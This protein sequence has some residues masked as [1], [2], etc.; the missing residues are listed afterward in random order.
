MLTRL[1]NKDEI[2][3]PSFAIS[4][5]SKYY[6]F[7]CDK[8]LRNIA[9][10]YR[11]RKNK[12]G[13]KLHAHTKALINRGIE[14]EK[15]ILNKLSNVFDCRE[16]SPSKS[17]DFL[18]NS[19]T[20]QVFYQLK[21]KVPEELYCDL[22]IVGIARFKHFVPDFIKVVEEDGEKK[23]MILDAK[24]SKTVRFSHQFQVASY[25]YLLNYVIEKI[26]GLSISRTG[27]IYLPPF[28][29]HTFRMD[30]ILPK[31]DQ[32]FRSELPRILSAQSV[33]WHYNSRCRTC[34]YVDDCRIDAEDSMAM[35]PYLSVEKAV[36]LK[37]LLQDWK[38]QQSALSANYLEGSAK[39]ILDESG[40]GEDADIE[41][42]ANYFD[43]LKIE[44]DKPSDRMIKQITKYDQHINN[45]PYIKARKDRQAQFVGT[46]TAT[47]PQKT[48]HNVIISMSVDPF[49]LRPFAW[50]VGLYSGDGNEIKSFCY[51]ESITG[52][53]EDETHAAFVTL[54]GNFIMRLEGIFEYLAK[55]NS[56]AC[57]FVF[58]TQE[59]LVIQ[60]SLL[61]IV[62]LDPS[63]I[64]PE[65]QN[66]ATRCLFN[67]F[68]DCS[69]L[70]ATSKNTDGDITE[71]P[72]GWREFPR[73]VIL[74]NAIQENVA[75]DVAGFY[76]FED[77][78]KQMVR[79]TIE[80]EDLRRDLDSEINAIDLENIYAIWSSCKVAEYEIN[81][82]HKFR[83]SFI[84]AVIQAYYALLAKSGYDIESKLLF[85]PPP[86]TL[87]E[88]RTFRH[89]YLGKLYFFKQFEAFSQCSQLKSGR[90]KDLILGEAV[91]GLRVKLEK[92]VKREGDEWIA[93]LEVMSSGNE[94]S[95][96]ESKSLKEFILVDDTPEA[97]GVLEAIRFPD[98]KYRAEFRRYP[99]T[100]LCI[101]E[102]INTVPSRKFIH[103]R[104]KFKK[105][106]DNTSTYRLYRRYIDFNLDKVLKTLIEIDEREY[107]RSVF[108]DILKDPNTW[109]STFPFESM[110]SKETKNLALKLRDSFGMSSSQKNISAKLLDRRLQIVWGPPGSGKTHFLSL[111]LTWYLTSMRPRPAGNNRNFIVGITAFT[112]AAI[113]NLLERISKVQKEKHRTSEFTLVRMVKDPKKKVANEDISDLKA[114]HL[115]RKIADSKIGIPGKPIVIGGTVWDWHKVRK[116]WKNK[117]AGCDI[118]IID[119]GSQLLVSDASIVLECLNPIE[120]RLIVAGDH[121]QLGPI[122]QNSYPV[123]PNDHPL[124]FGSI[125]QCLMRRED[126]TVF[127]EMDFFLKRGKKYDF[128]P[129]TIQLTDN[130]RMNEELT[131]FFQKIY[132]DDYISKSPNLKLS[133]EDPKLRHITNP[134]VRRALDPNSAIDMVKITM[135]NHEPLADLRFP[136]SVLSSEQFLQTEA[137]V[138]AQIA[139]AYFSSPQPEKPSLFVVTP[140]HRQRHAIRSRLL[141]YTSNPDF[142]LMIDTVEKI[143]GQ[144]ADLVIACFCFFDANE[145]AR[146]S[147][148]LFDRNR[149]NVA[150]SRARCKVIII[151]T[152]EML[153]PKRMEVFTNKR[154][155]EG[156]VFLSMIESWVKNK[157]GKGKNLG[158]I[159]WEFEEETEE[160]NVSIT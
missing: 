64:S 116:E 152:D 157:M 69:L 54:M 26:R 138:V 121:M 55:K 104:G 53:K 122:I 153:Y 43:S 119:E 158:V 60:N 94:L 23:L 41:D 120:G 67:L 1:S 20:G 25:A 63:T 61:E 46:P 87:T 90:M 62:L 105:R 51:A 80:D 136:A 114:E 86:F 135:A 124:I 100:M 74:E 59:K 89:H 12:D 132:G 35:I 127:K 109:G 2:E 150:V 142:N 48:N 118:L 47:F 7:S 143:Q 131:K 72:G 75:M 98:M 8:L 137:N 123:F 128:G 84:N 156:W 113:D 93:C 129:S 139:V 77:V 36:D 134:Y 79:H 147:E 92:F 148:F 151:T 85:S 125:Q 91:S 106:I 38:N 4:D 140:H 149:W 33:P 146:E 16:I 52:K 42:L 9:S 81:N 14:F 117:W 32:F 28:E 130:W 145:I 27:G 115:P 82:S 155:S 78:W 108:L 95:L 160:N 88:V 96:L 154:A 3:T 18:R 73:L 65:I 17:R 57:V 111:F 13:G 21:V 99:L 19:R 40:C 30:F 22:G 97:R 58:S 6:Q 159:E 70:L 37:I 110:N 141:E 56:R 71:I 112:R 66:A 44:D 15:Q 101:Q 102:S 45:S 133:F 39:D 144:Q 107:E 34:E 126:G 5:L 49:L 83:L 10:E 50:G 103:V 29:L 76:R 31:V 24:I 11:K 68:E